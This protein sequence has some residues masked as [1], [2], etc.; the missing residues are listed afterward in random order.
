MRATA[1]ICLFADDDVVYND[2]YSEIVE[3]EF[4]KNPKADVIVF[5][6]KQRREGEILQDSVFKNGFIGRKKASPY[7]T[8]L[9][10]FRSA[11]IKAQN[12]MFHRMFGGG[13]EY[14]CGEDTIFL[15]D[16]IKKGLKVYRTT[17]LIGTVIH[18]ESTWFKGYSDKY[19][20][21][22][23]VIYNYL[24][25]FLAKPLCFYHV[26]KHRKMYKGYGVKKA[27]HQMWKGTKVNF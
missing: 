13:T 5:N 1:E 4:A 8:F 20:Y 3:K 14:S 17:A 16:C 11:R 2:D 9:I 27:I 26:I 15:Q 6:M 22:K 23:G 12:V 7:G 25:P 18:S 10:G 19:F 21:D 24:F